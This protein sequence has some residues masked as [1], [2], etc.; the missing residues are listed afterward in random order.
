MTDRTVNRRSAE[1]GFTL[2]E[3]MVTLVL[4]SI[5]ILA[6]SGVQTRSSSDVYDTGRH[7][8][9]LALAQEQIEVARAAGYALAASTAGTSGGFAWATQVDTVSA[10]MKQVAVTVT[11]NDRTRVRNLQLQT[12]LS[13][14]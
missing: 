11:W 6:L 2:I 1:A 3:L 5:G 10:D 12:L 7:E 4:I 13:E 8:R 14:R 9:A